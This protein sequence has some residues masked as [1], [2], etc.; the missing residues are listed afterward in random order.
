MVVD[1]TPGYDAPHCLYA[2]TNRELIYQWYLILE[3]DEEE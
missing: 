3:Q 1:I 2:Q